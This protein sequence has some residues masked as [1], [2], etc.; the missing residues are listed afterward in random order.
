MVTDAVVERVVITA[1]V[2]GAGPCVVTTT[3]VVAGCVVVDGA[4]AVAK[5]FKFRL[6]FSNTVL[7][8][9]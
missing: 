2:V 3:D 6:L 5:T 9:A 7:A 4:V 1:L 8:P